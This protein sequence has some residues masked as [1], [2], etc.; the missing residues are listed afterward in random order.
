MLQSFP[1]VI[2]KS[3]TIL[4]LGSMPG[5]VSLRKHEYYGNLRNHFWPIMYELFHEPIAESYEQRLAFLLNKR[6][7]LWDVIQNCE[8]EG[9]LD[10]AIKY[11]KI[12][13]FDS[14]YEHYPAI[15]AILFNGTKAYQSYKKYRGFSDGRLYLTL[16]S[17]SPTPSRYI[18]NMQ[19]KLGKWQIVLDLLGERKDE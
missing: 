11:E 3:C 14:L 15:Q 13:D 4:I 7:A 9:S 1:P 5:A 8:R 18:K 16:P 10:S 2:N 17:T 19:D 6:I 12:N